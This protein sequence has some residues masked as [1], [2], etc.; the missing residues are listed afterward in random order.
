MQCILGTGPKD[1][2]KA[3]A[4][5]QQRGPAAGGLLKGYLQ[6]VESTALA[7]FTTLASARAKSINFNSPQKKTFSIGIFRFLYKVVAF[8]FLNCLEFSAGLGL[9]NG[10]DQSGGASSI[11]IDAKNVRKVLVPCALL[12]ALR[13]ILTSAAAAGVARSGNSSGLLGNA[14][15][16]AAVGSS[17]DPLCQHAACIISR[18]LKAVASQRQQQQVFQLK[19]CILEILSFHLSIMKC[20]F[21]SICILCR[22]W[23]L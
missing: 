13:R 21:K 23:V 20:S 17:Y 16:L 5:G 4:V 11:A 2:D 7:V 19:N 9:G 8:S 12:S 10:K 6:A 15:I 3:T 14:T 18:S 1:G 22:N